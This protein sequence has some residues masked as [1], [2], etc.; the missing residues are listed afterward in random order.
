MKNVISGSPTFY[1][2]ISCFYDEM[3]N[4]D[5]LLIS[6]SGLLKK[7]ILPG[8]KTAADLGCG[9]GIDSVSLALA[10]MDV[11]A[12]D[13]SKG[14]IKE[15]KKNS[16]NRG[17]NI[18][19]IKSGI[20]KIPI[21]FSEK[22]DLALSLGNTLANLDHR[23]LNAAIKKIFMILKPGGKVVIQI[24]NFMLIKEK[25]K[26]IVKIT[27]VNNNTIIRFYDIFKEK[28]NF[29]ILRF[30]NINPSDYSLN[31]SSIY[32][33]DANTIKNILQKSGLT[34]IKYYGDLKLNKFEKNS[35]GDLVII[36]FKN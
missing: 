32:P 7:F 8:M 34:N 30:N 19:F 3:I 21:N 13:I 36:A 5:T 12:F 1:D 33:Y 11:T 18:N 17:L 28:F 26:R 6:R 24:L 9:T 10:G 16:S 15:A 35:S 14:M 23:A 4:F 27:E 2:N 31:T 20:D 25:N 29:N 22:F